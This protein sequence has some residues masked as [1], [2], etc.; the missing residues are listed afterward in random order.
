LQAIT[1]ALAP[2]QGRRRNV[3]SEMEKGS[4]VA[5]VELMKRI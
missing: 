2:S 1:I 5:A 4:A 3:T